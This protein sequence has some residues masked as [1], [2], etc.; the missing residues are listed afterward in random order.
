MKDKNQDSYLEQCIRALP[1]EK[2]S[3][4]RK[5][6]EELGDG[7]LGALSRVLIA[8]E[9]TTALAKE[10]P[11]DLAEVSR[12]L[13]DELDARRKQAEQTAVELEKQREERLR[14]LLIQQVPALG[15]ALAVDRIAVQVEQQKA[16]TL[17]LERSVSRF[18]HLRVGGVLALMLCSVILVG[19]GGAAFWWKDIQSWRH[20]AQFLSR[21]DRAGVS[22]RLM[23]QDQG[24]T[25]FEIK[26]PVYQ[27][28]GWIK[29]AN[30][31]L[32]GADLVIQEGN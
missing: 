14:A 29:D 2:Q 20:N 28:T 30:G 9:A 26:G 3:A 25:V 19:A 5:A 27:G 4:A 17:R 32:A 6:F 12:R 22:L 8:L 16:A 23:R 15:R 10:V 18:R 1:H 21:L 7:D 24:G 11:R 13:L 31:N